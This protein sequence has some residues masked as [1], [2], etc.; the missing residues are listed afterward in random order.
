MKS[1]VHRLAVSY[2]MQHMLH[3]DFKHVK[4]ATCAVNAESWLAN[5]HVP[6]VATATSATA[7][8]ASLTT[9]LLSY[10]LLNRLLLFLYFCVIATIIRWS[11]T[12]MLG[13]SASTH[14]V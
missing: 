3:A 11:G 14:S 2:G 6:M 12:K 13:Q 1:T 9:T 5:M 10:S 8:S 4:C 7:A